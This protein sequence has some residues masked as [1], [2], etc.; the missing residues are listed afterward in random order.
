MTPDGLTDETTKP[1]SATASDKHLPPPAAEA[2]MHAV[3][4]ALRSPQP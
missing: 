2:G 4:E 1:A 3:N